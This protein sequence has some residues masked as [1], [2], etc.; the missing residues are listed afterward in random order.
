MIRKSFIS[1]VF[2]LLLLFG[3]AYGF[4]RLSSVTDT[5]APDSFVPPSVKSPGAGEFF[6]N[7]AALQ[8]SS[9]ENAKDPSEQ[10]K[11]FCAALS[12]AGKALVSRPYDARYLLSWA[13]LRQLSGLTDCGLPFTGGSY[14]EALRKARESEP[15]DPSVLYQSAQILVWGGKRGEA[16]HTMRAALQF[17]LVL[18]PP[19]QQFIGSIIRTP[20]DVRTVIPPRFPQVVKWSRLLSGNQTRQSI[21]RESLSSLQNEALDESRDDFRAGRIPGVVYLERLTSLYELSD[22]DD[23]VRRKT[24]EMAAE[25]LDRRGNGESVAHLKARAALA[26]LDVVRGVSPDDTRPLRGILSNWA[27]PIGICA[28]AYFQSI[29][30]YLPVNQAVKMIEVESR[31]GGGRGDDGMFQLYVS[32][33]NQEWRELNAE[34]AFADTS[35][36]NTN[37]LVFKIPALRSKYWK[38]HFAGSKRA[39]SVC[40]SINLLLRVYGSALY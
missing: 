6:F 25:Y 23:A 22:L 38:V 36:R 26:R 37:T 35:F 39:P 12:S 21:L 2:I 1:I 19:Q 9:G 15:V 27:D 24:D 5:S 29:G 33:N 14:E 28:D 17:D 16:L 20:E 30:F 13:S 7:Q 32:D 8:Y 11:N 3:A 31:G 4:V 40:G 34:K 10:L 18:T